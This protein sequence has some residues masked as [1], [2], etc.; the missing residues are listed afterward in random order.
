MDPVLS[1]SYTTVAAF[2]ESTEG[3][4]RQAI[5]VNC[6]CKYEAHADCNDF[7]F[8]PGHDCKPIILPVKDLEKFVG[9]KIDKSECVAILSSQVF[10]RLYSKWIGLATTSSTECPIQQLLSSNNT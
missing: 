10:I 4:F 6:N 1:V 7:L 9:D 2:L 3:N 5:Y 8:V